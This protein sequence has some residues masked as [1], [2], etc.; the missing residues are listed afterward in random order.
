MFELT[1]LIGILPV[2]ERDEAPNRGPELGLVLGGL[3]PGIAIFEW[4]QH[5][6]ERRARFGSH[7]LKMGRSAH[8]QAVDNAG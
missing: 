3:V 5:L 2:V 7:G 8:S 4:R 6:P 1:G